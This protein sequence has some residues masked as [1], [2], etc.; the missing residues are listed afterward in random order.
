MIRFRIK[1]LMEERG[2]R[3][4][5]IEP[6]VKL[7]ISYDIVVEY[8]NGKRKHIEREHMEKFCFFLRC[9]PNDLF[10]YVPD[11][12]L[13]FD[14]HHPIQQIRQRQPFNLMDAVKNLSPDEIRKKFEG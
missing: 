13:P 8:L 11:N 2:I 5:K 1:E 10:E 4:P 6:L 7:G 12:K 14:E 9:A 3:K